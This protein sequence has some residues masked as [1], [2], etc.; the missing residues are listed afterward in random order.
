MYRC[1]RIWTNGGI[2]TYGEC[3][4]IWVIQM[5]GSVHM[6]EGMDIWRHIDI[7]GVWTYGDIQMYWGV[8]T[9][10]DVWTWGVW[11]YG[12]IWTW[13]CMDILGVYGCTCL[14]TTPEGI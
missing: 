14:P 12:G 6:Y 11:L 1:I 8:Q 5:Y 7:W 2:L 13:G 4:D 3:M 9:Y 10:Q